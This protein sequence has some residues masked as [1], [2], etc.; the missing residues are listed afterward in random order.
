MCGRFTQKLSRRRIHSLYRLKGPTPPVHLQP[1]YNGAPGQDFAAC[2]L[3]ET[4]NRAIAQ[5]RWG[6]VP[7]WSR[8]ASIGTR[9]INARAETVHAKPSFGDA[10]RSR[11]CLVPADGWFEWQ[12]VGRGRQPCFLTPADGSPLSFAALWERWGSGEDSLESFAIIT[13]TASSALADVH[14][15]Q[16]AIIDPDR[17]DDWLDPASPEPRLLDLVRTPFDGPYERRAVSTRVNDVRNDDP[18]VLA[19][20][21]GPAKELF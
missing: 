12:P 6:L 1:R 16:P 2:R 5:L 19:P 8:D 3:D 15:R 14:P 21:P 18:S 10:F 20:T 4:G 13:T 9:L 17:F 7:S 11:R